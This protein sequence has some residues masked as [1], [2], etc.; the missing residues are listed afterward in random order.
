MIVAAMLLPLLALSMC[1]A[2]S[3][4]HFANTNPTG[5]DLPGYSYQV[6]A[7]SPNCVPTP[8]MPWRPIANCLA[9]MAHWQW[10]INSRIRE[11]PMLMAGTRFGMSIRALFLRANDCGC[12]VAKNRQFNQKKKTRVDKML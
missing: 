2:N 1:A 4:E 3:C 6:E 9:T 5:K 7:N 11:L 8:A 10:S 12:R